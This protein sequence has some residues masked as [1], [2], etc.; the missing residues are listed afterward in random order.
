MALTMPGAGVHDDVPDGRALASQLAARIPIPTQLPVRHDGRRLTHLSKSSYELWCTCREAWR[1]RYILGEREPT[2]AA[3]FLG[4]RVDDAVSDYYRHILEH[5][6]PSPLDEV[7]H[8]YRNGWSERLEEE[9]QDRGV[10][11]DEFDEPTMLKI[12]V[13]AIKATFERLVPQLGMP[14]AVQ[15]RVAFKL[16]PGL[17]WWIEGYLDLEAQSVALDGE[18]VDEIVD[19]KVKGGDAIS[20]DKADRDPQPSVYLTGRWLEGPRPA[21]RFAFAQVLRPGRKRKST[22]T[23]LVRTQR[24]VGQMRATLARFAL[25]ASEIAACYDQFG[26]DRPWGLADPTSWKCS[27]RYCSYWAGCPGGAGL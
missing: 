19:Y 13:D 21:D 27:E 2:S 14:V 16:A 5:G 26:P 11:F 22:S 10:V 15:R 12:G 8:G 25:A 24:T 7:I 17:E 18:I 9:Q 3:M 20:K 1:R 6:E 23:S 4:S